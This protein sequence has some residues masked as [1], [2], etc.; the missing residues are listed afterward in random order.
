M[1]KAVEQE[2]TVKKHLQA[3]GVKIALA[4]EGKKV[5]LYPKKTTFSLYFREGRKG[6]GGKDKI[7]VRVMTVSAHVLQGHRESHQFAGI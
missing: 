1:S 3:G 7:R 4:L 6:R 2:A 5:V